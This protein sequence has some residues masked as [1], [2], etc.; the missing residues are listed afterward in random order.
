MEHVNTKIDNYINRFLFPIKHHSDYII[1]SKKKLTS[2][3]PIVPKKIISISR[4]SEREEQ[5][6][7]YIKNKRDTIEN[8]IFDLK[9]K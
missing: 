3:S 9:Y 1:N 8:N 5:G 4:D 6:I 7:K 2:K